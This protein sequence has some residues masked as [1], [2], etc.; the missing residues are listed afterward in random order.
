MGTSSTEIN[1]KFA[2]GAEQDQTAHTYV[3][4]DLALHVRKIN[5]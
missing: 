3:Q 2:E 1:D 5:P 4:S